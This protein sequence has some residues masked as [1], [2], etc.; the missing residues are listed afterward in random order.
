[1][2]DK[3]YMGSNHALTVDENKK[4]TRT[5]R[6]FTRDIQVSNSETFAGNYR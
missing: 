1:M 3:K 2:S 6:K 5:D 4:T